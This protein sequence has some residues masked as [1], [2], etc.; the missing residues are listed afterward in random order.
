MADLTFYTQV[1]DRGVRDGLQRIET[2]TKAFAGRYSKVL[3]GS[4]ALGAAGAAVAVLVA[5]ISQANTRLAETSA[6]A[7]EE[8]DQYN[9]AWAR[10]DDT[11]GRVGG[12]WRALQ[13]SVVQGGASLLESLFG[14]TYDADRARDRMVA[15]QKLVEAARQ[16]LDALNRET[17][18]DLLKSQS[19][20]AAELARLE[21]EREDRLAKITDLVKGLGD[22]EQK[23]L[24]VARLRQQVL[25]AER[26][27]REAIALETEDKARTDALELDA[28][29]RSLGEALDTLKAQNEV[30]ILRA[31]GLDEQARQAEI[32]LRFEQQIR[33]VRTDQA[34]DDR[35]Q[36]AR[37]AGLLRQRDTLL[38][39]REPREFST[40]L[41]GPGLSGTGL[42]GQ[43]FGG[44][45]TATAEADTRRNTQRAADAGERSAKL[46][47]SIDRKINAGSGFGG[48]AG[49]AVFG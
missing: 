48:G 46:L 25:D 15:L 21:Q 3:G 29:R 20:N 13:T 5:Q 26:A 47:E 24:G 19:G 17:Q 32:R 6:T 14:S 41:L 44:P 18:N 38:N 23:I 35:E 42:L 7:R 27:Q 2:A 37:I 11:L 31:R 45:G 39:L 43:V 8:I 16:P 1:D 49:A 4:L 36:S 33:Q 34:L 28:R 22:A 10:L 30:E 12:G 9:A 40:R